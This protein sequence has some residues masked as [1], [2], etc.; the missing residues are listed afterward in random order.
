M[1]SSTDVQRSWPAWTCGHLRHATCGV[2][3]IGSGFSDVLGHHTPGTND[4]IITDVH[5][6]DGGVGSNADTIADVGFF[7]LCLVATGGPSDLERVVDE[8]RAMADETVL[9]NGHEFTDEGVGLYT[10]SRTDAGPSLNFN[11]RAH[12]HTV[13]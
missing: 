1:T 2:A 13:C 10:S 7:P 12:K 6:H 8:H 3:C 9:S 11:K 5:R 4:H